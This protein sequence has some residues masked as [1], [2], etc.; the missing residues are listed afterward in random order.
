[1][2]GETPGG[3][4]PRRSVILAAVMAGA[5]LGPIDASIV[6]VVLPTLSRFFDASLATVQ[7]VPMAY[8]L[9]SGSLVLLFGRL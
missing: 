3:E 9:A 2:S 5:I 7:W 4:A 6:N 1:M 8:L